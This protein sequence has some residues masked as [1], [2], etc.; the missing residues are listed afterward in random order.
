MKTSPAPSRIKT[1][2]CK[3]FSQNEMLTTYNMS[4]ERAREIAQVAIDKAIARGSDRVALEDVL[5]SW[6]FGRH[7]QLLLQLDPLIP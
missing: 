4:R 2:P 7:I 1:I 3:G 5:S 6:E